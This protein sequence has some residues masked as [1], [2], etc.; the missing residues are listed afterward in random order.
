MPCALPRKDLLKTLLRVLVKLEFSLNRLFEN[1]NFKITFWKPWIN[2]WWSQKTLM[3]TIQPWPTTQQS[4]HDQIKS[5]RPPPIQESHPG[6]KPQH[7]GCRQKF[8]KKSNQIESPFCLLF[9]TLATWTFHPSQVLLLSCASRSKW[10]GEPCWAPGTLYVSGSLET[11][12][13]FVLKL[14]GKKNR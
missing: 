10:V 7:W 3:M 14:V 12:L 6:M 8:L 1:Y 9:F 11:L 5:L 13:K 4:R 2:T